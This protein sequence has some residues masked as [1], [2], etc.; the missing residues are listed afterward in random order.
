[1]LYINNVSIDIIISVTLIYFVKIEF[2][3]QVIALFSSF[4][5]FQLKATRIKVPHVIYCKIY[6]YLYYNLLSII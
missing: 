1:M 2:N 4:Y 5:V 3:P 6:C